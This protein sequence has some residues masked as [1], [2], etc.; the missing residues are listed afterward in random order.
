MAIRNPKSKIKNPKSKTPLIVVVNDDGIQSPGIRALARAMA[1]LGEVLVV[2]PR[3]QQT[4]MGRAFVGAGVAEVADFVVGGKRLRAFAVPTSPALAVRYAL[5]VHAEREPALVVSGINYGENI[6]NGVT[7]SGTVGAGLEAA[8]MG[9]RVLTVS[10][11]V[12]VS[13]HFT[14]NDK[15]DFSV[16]AQFAKRWARH[17]LE[18][19]MPRGADIVNLNV[20]AGARTTTPWR[21]TR[22][23]RM[24]YY[25]SIITTTPQ[26]KSL[27]SY[28]L[29]LDPDSPEPDSDVRAVMIDHVVSVSCL[30]Y[31]LT[32]RVAPT[33]FARWAK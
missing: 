16:A 28:E 26:G 30:S 25:R 11:V 24:N 5:L 20:P 6:G 8:S 2:A 17:I 31:D 12:P 21:F 3:E 9:A 4:S 18:R 22:V 33:E 1:D 23:S 27:D 15:V 14:H 7:I 19:G 10:Q 13:Y 32:A 29:F